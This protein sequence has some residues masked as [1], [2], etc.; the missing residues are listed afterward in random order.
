MMFEHFSWRVWLDITHTSL[1]NTYD[2]KF[3]T[4]GYSLDSVSHMKNLCVA[5]YHNSAL[6]K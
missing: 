3:G 5:R 4:L 2:L 1:L 6:A